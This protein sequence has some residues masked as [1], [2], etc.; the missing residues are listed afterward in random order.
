MP[1]GQ[2]F[3]LKGTYFET[4]NRVTVLATISAAGD[5]VHPLLIFKGKRLP[6]RVLLLLPDGS[7]TTESAASLL[8][9]DSLLTTRPEIG[10]M[11]DRI[12]M[13]WCKNFV[14]RISYLTANGR[15]VLHVYDG[16]RSHMILRCLKTLKE[17]SV[18]AYAIPAHTSGT[19]Q[20]LDISVFGPF[21][22]AINEFLSQLSKSI[23]SCLGR[24]SKVTLY[25]ICEAFT[26]SYY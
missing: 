10:G 25:D 18:E 14:Q 17:G 5:A 8:P 12:F 19:T 26:K 21:K 3:Y 9:P 24:R 7:E 15:R 20:P 11:D 13:L 1:R 4:V 23:G 22:K 2:R 6:Y 16:H